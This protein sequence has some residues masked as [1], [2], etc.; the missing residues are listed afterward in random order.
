MNIKNEN[1]TKP[2]NSKINKIRFGLAWNVFL[3]QI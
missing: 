1:P 3:S 2:T